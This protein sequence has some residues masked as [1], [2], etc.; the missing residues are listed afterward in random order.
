MLVATNAFL[1]PHHVLDASG[2][3]TKGCGG[4]TKG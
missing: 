2:S 3:E 1:K 4:W